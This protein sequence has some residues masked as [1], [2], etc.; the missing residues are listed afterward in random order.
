MTSHQELDT[1]APR[2][3]TADDRPATPEPA[4][5]DAESR[6]AS[7]ETAV[8]SA[9]AIAR[10]V[11]E[12]AGEDQEAARLLRQAQA[13]AFYIFLD[14]IQDALEQGIQPWD[15]PF[16]PTNRHWLRADLGIKTD[17]EGEQELLR[18]LHEIGVVRLEETDT[19][20]RLWLS[21]AICVRSEA[22]E[23]LNWNVV[24][25]TWVPSDYIFRLVLLDHLDPTG[26]LSRVAKSTLLENAGMSR[27]ALKRALSRE[28]DKEIITRAYANQN[29]LL[30]A[31]GPRSLA[32]TGR[33]RHDREAAEDAPASPWRR[34]GVAPDAEVNVPRAA[35]VDTAQTV[36]FHQPVRIEVPEGAS[37]ATVGIDADGIK[38][39]RVALGDAREPMHD[40]EAMTVSPGGRGSDR[41]VADRGAPRGAADRS[42]PGERGTERQGGSSF[43]G[44]RDAGER[45][46]GA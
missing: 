31:W 20:P 22:A 45:S 3:G 29:E 4:T 8:V 40:D 36:T 23:R 24:G 13:V 7:G 44:Y 42:A 19:G 41:E 35:A 1:L 15:V 27:S 16:R 2:P 18:R 17:A 46:S 25:N 34:S 11:R 39:Y 32:R 21:P 38:R 10:M 5:R 28:A 37:V 9:A 14:V 26:A 33:R 12:H 6:D 43:G 30:L